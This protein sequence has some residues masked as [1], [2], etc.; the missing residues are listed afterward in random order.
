MKETL[1]PLID[2]A[3]PYLGRETNGVETIFKRLSRGGNVTIGNP[4]VIDYF[5]GPPSPAKIAPQNP[6]KP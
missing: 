2:S 1:P 4:T 6:P 3:A 5:S